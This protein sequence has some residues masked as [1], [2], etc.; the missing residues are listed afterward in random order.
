MLVTAVFIATSVVDRGLWLDCVKAMAEAAMV[1]ALA[2]WFAVV[3]LFR[4]PLGLPIPHTVVIA[5]NLAT[6]VRDKFLDMPSSGTARS[7]LSKPGL[8]RSLIDAA[9]LG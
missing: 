3:A 6:V 2:D 1:G 7:G 4:K 9:C 5:R 8:A